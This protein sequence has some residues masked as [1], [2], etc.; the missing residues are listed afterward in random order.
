MNLTAN[1][2]EL[3]EERLLKNFYRYK[4]AEQFTDYDNDQ[5]R[6][7]RENDSVAI[8]LREDFKKDQFNYYTFLY[9]AQEVREIAE[10]TG[11]LFIY[12]MPY[13]EYMHRK[14]L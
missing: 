11:Y 9:D 5:Y 4:V 10:R 8:K 7:W 13:S 2:R 12:S 14:E 3:Y 1:N 6:N